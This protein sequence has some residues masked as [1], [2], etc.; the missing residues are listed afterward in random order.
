MFYPPPHQTHNSP[1]TIYVTTVCVI[2][3][4]SMFLAVCRN[5]QGVY[6]LVPSPRRLR[7]TGQQSQPGRP[8]APAV[9]WTV[10]FWIFVLW[11]VTSVER[12]GT[13]M[14][15]HDSLLQN[16]SVGDN[17]AA[18]AFTPTYIDDLTRVLLY[19]C[20]SLGYESTGMEGAGNNG[21]AG[22]GIHEDIIS[23]LPANPQ[24]WVFSNMNCSPATFLVVME[25]VLFLEDV[26][27]CPSSAVGQVLLSRRSINPNPWRVLDQLPSHNGSVFEGF[28]AS[29]VAEFRQ[30]QNADDD[31]PHL[32]WQYM[33][34]LPW[35]LGEPGPP[36]G[37]PG[38]VQPE[39][40]PAELAFQVRWSR[41]KQRGKTGLEMGAGD[42]LPVLN[43]N[44]DERRM[45][46]SDMSFCGPGV[47]RAATKAFKGI[48]GDLPLL[49]Q[50]TWTQGSGT[51]NCPKKV[52]IDVER[53]ADRESFAV[54][55]MGNRSPDKKGISS[56]AGILLQT[57]GSYLTP[58][59][60]S[61]TYVL[62][63]AVCYHPHR[64]WSSFFVLDDGRVMDY[65]TLGQH[66]GL[67]AERAQK[68]CTA[69]RQP[70]HIMGCTSP[71]NMSACMSPRLCKAKCAW[72]GPNPAENRTEH[73]AKV[74]V[75]IFRRGYG[76]NVRPDPLCSEARK[77]WEARRADST[78]PKPPP[79]KPPDFPKS[80]V[81]KDQKSKGV[82]VSTP[83]AMLTP[84]QLSPKRAFPHIQ[85]LD[86]GWKVNEDPTGSDAAV[87]RKRRFQDLQPA[88]LGWT[89]TDEPSGTVPGNPVRGPAV[90]PEV[91]TANMQFLLSCLGRCGYHYEPPGLL[92]S[93]RTTAG[94]TFADH[95]AKVAGLLLYH[96]GQS[97]M[98]VHDESGPFMFYSGLD[99]TSKG[100]IREAK[101]TPAA[102]EPGFLD[103]VRELVRVATPDT[104]HEFVDRGEVQLAE[105]GFLVENVPNK[106]SRTIGPKNAQHGSYTWCRETT[107][108]F[109]GHQY[110]KSRS[111]PGLWSTRQLL[112]A[113]RDHPSHMWPSTGLVAATQGRQGLMHVDNRQ[114]CDEANLVII[115]I[116]SEYGG[117]SGRASLL[118]GL[119]L[120][121]SVP[122]MAM[123][124]VTLASSTIVS[125]LLCSPHQ[126]IEVSDVGTRL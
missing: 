47:N 71:Y 74:K 79:N 27:V 43:V 2:E 15:A 56:L 112:E 75:A 66:C 20:R 32:P 42:V 7:P 62:S 125:L 67:L 97:S 53:G 21:H 57:L 33:N 44:F 104:V 13:S 58:G 87:S 10:W 80:S 96:H 48:V 16:D 121:P 95:A 9:V 1:R 118:F 34:A 102:Q 8:N 6:V 78:L 115:V 119:I 92:P 103:L 26:P 5:V 84:D 89:G 76:L 72:I 91:V 93:T 14:F 65:D 45:T 36:P 120:L 19:P 90:S 123:F 86:L 12:S 29:M 111:S 61:Q 55:V 85:P 37:T 18:L 39:P 99:G 63:A 31:W 106:T 83:A 40:T 51:V 3:P 108:D 24:Y 49:F 81:S 64:H 23:L 124:R 11:S 35:L 17:V 114:P 105:S 126:C 113:S 41:S 59:T 107:D 117:T 100:G 28:H 38:L 50:V 101:T 122:P 68:T 30:E 82:D 70:G 69:G 88:D 116:L 73:K 109:G 46:E 94:M 22:D 54:A 110:V 60:M 98:R 77:L 25:V 4:G 52:T